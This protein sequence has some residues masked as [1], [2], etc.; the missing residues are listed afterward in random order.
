V[1]R[2]VAAFSF[3]DAATRQVLPTIQSQ[4]A[5][6]ANESCDKSQ[7]SKYLTT[8]RSQYNLSRALQQ[9]KT[10][11]PRGYQLWD[12]SKKKHPSEDRQTSKT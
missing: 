7:Q 6:A 10:A 8:C 4:N 3:C 12:A 9:N 5:F 11:A 1:R 2:L